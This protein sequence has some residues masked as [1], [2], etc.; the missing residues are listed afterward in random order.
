MSGHEVAKMNE[1]CIS[2]GSQEKGTL[3]FRHWIF[4]ISQEATAFIWINEL[5]D[6]N[7]TSIKHILTFPLAYFEVQSIWGIFFL[8]LVVIIL[9][10]HNLKI[11]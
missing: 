11:D 3:N 2:T 10:N 8:L 5:Y 7:K 1:H 4:G 9:L 6:T